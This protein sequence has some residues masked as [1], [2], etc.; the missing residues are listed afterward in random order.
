[1]WRLT[2]IALINVCMFYDDVFDKAGGS[3]KSQLW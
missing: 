2:E 3:E 1:M